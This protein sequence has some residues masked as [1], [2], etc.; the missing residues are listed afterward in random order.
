M[1]SRYIKKLDKAKETVLGTIW[2]Q[3]GRAE[4]ANLMEEMVKRWVVLSILL[5]EDGCCTKGGPHLKF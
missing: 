5:W 4:N 2:H 1:F 3:S